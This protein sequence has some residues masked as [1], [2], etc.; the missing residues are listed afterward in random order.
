MIPLYIYIYIKMSCGQFIRLLYTMYS[1]N[2]N[3][4]NNDRYSI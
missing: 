1:N 2:N 4:Y 3:R